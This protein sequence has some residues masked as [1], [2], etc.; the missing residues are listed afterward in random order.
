MPSRRR[1]LIGIALAAAFASTSAV[2]HHGHEHDDAHEQAQ[3]PAKVVGTVT[4]PA[5]VVADPQHD[6]SVA[7]EQTGVLEAPPGGFPTP[8][9]A[10]VAGQVLGYLHPAIPQSER[11]DLESD[12]TLA[13]RD[14]DLG[15]LQVKRYAVD[16][17]QKP[18]IMLPTQSLQTLLDYRAARVRE[19]QYASTQNARIAL[20]APMSGEVV[21]SIAREGLIAAP[22][23]RLFELAGASALSIESQFGD[24]DPLPE[25]AHQVRTRRGDLVEVVFQSASFDASRRSRRALYRVTTASALLA[26]GEPQQ[27]L[28]EAE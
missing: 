14:V 9:Q 19:T 27:L 4:L 17:N 15:K 13:R 26:I 28:V 16:E 11:R 23:I 24:R 10:V 25:H 6:F 12:L 2:A 8:G 5:R 22:G 20:V 1:S 7:V 18:D 3:P 21:A